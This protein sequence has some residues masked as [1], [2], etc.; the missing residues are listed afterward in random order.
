MRCQGCGRIEQALTRPFCGPCE[1]VLHEALT[2][3]VVE[4][5]NTPV[6]QRVVR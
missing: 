3:V 2:E 4:L 1:R 6:E 5:K